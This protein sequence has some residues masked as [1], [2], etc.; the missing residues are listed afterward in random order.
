V[1]A[2][3]DEPS[4][5]W[6]LDVPQYSGIG[7]VLALNN[8]IQKAYTVSPFIFRFRG[9]QDVDGFDELP[10]APGAAAELAQDV[11]G[12]ELAAGALAGSARPG[13]A[14]A[15]SASC[16]ALLSGNLLHRFVVR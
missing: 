3:A 4:E 6:Q 14:W 2:I 9:L 12:L 10:G 16:T 5:S 15:R 11:P 13:R 8:R 7:A 1:Q